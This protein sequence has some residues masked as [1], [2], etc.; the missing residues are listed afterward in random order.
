M[1]Y[2]RVVRATDV[3]AIT[4]IEDT[5][6]KDSYVFMLGTDLAEPLFVTGRLIPYISRETLLKSTPPAY[7]MTTGAAYDPVKDLAQ[8]TDAW[9]SQRNAKHVYVL[10][11][12]SMRIFDERYGQ[13]L[14]SDQTRLETQLRSNTVS[15]QVV[16]DQSGARVYEFLG[17][18]P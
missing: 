5:V 6:P 7:P 1:D 4:W 14:I 8:L 10:A 16:Y 15:W 12:D 17:V 13:Q 11:T 18:S 9:A 2:S 3:A